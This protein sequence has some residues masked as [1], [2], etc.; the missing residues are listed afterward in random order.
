LRIFDGIGAEDPQRSSLALAGGPLGF[1]FERDA[2]VGA[3]VAAEEAD[4]TEAAPLMHVL[5]LVAEKA[6]VIRGPGTH[7]DDRSDGDGVGA[8]RDGTANPEPVVA[9]PPEGHCAS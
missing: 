7:R 6:L 4:G 9:V 2:A 1:H 3:Q 8:W 5:P